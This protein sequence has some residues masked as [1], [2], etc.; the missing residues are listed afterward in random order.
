M[1]MGVGYTLT[2]TL[3]ASIREILGSGTW[4]G[5]PGDPGKRCQGLHHDA[6]PAHS[7]AWPVDGRLCGWKASWMPASSARAAATLIT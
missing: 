6:A 5:L 7:S 2:A 4:S 1:G 3:M